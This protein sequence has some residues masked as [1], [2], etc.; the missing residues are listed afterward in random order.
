MR[1][2]EI[3]TFVLLAAGAGVAQKA[4]STATTTAPSPTVGASPG[5]TTNTPNNN[6]SPFPDTTGLGQRPIFISGKVVLSDGT[7]LPDRVK[8]AFEKAG[9]FL[10]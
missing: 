9:V 10:L 6:T 3:A 1:S 8:I 4:G 7:P 2:F 5:R